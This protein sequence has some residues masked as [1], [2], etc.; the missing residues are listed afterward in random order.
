MAALRSPEGGCP[1][2]LQQSYE[3]IAPYTLEE[4]YEVVDAIDRGNINDLREELGDLLFQSIYHAQMA[5]EEGYFDIHDVINDVSKKMISRHPHVFADKSANCAE[6]VDKIW[7]EQKSKE[8]KENNDN[9]SSVLDGVAK[10]LPALLRAQ[11]LQNKAAKVGFKWDNVTQ[12]LDKLEE[13]IQEMREAVTNKDKE[14]QAEELGDLLFL[15]VN[16]G[17]M[18]G[19]NSEEALRRCNNKFIRRFKGVEEDLKR[20]GL[21]IE[22]ASLIDM[23][24]AWDRQKNKEKL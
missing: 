6:D 1:W 12:L 20:Q 9:P 3:S 16:Y 2:D 23:E 17:R 7:N 21:P 11:K 10:A 4:A 22:K 14:N 5:S 13:E 18:L 19:I 8:N 15:L 24:K